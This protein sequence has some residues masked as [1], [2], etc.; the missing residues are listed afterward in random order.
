MQIKDDFQKLILV[1]EDEGL[2]AAD[3]QR[4]IERLGY[5][6]P[7]IARSGEE[8]L[9]R[10]R[11]TPFD[12]VLMDIRLKGEMDGVATAEALRSELQTSVVYL[13][14]HADQETIERAKLTEPLGYIL[15]PISDGDLRSVMQTSIYKA[16]MDRRLRTSEAWLA[17]TL[18]SVG[19]G[20][21]AT[22]SDG[23]VVFMNPCAERLTGWLGAEAQGRVLM[24][25]LG[26][27]E[28]SSRQPAK[29]PVFDLAEGENRTYT[30]VS[31]AG[32]RTLVELECFENRSADEVLGSIVTVRDIGIRRERDS[33]LLQ[34]ERME[35]I[36][37]LAGGLAHDFNNQLTVILGYADELG[38]RLTGDD[39]DQILEIQQAA[40]LAASTTT[41]LLALSRRGGVRFEVLNVND[42]ISEV[43]PMISHNL[44][45][46][47]ILTTQLGSPLGYIRADRAQFKQLFLHLALNAR[48]SMPAGGEMRIESSTLEIGEDSALARQYRPGTYVRLRVSDTGEGLDADT[49]SRIFEPRFNTMK[50]QFGSG[51]GLSMVHS[52]VLQG[53]GYIGAESEVGKGTSFEILLPCVGTFRGPNE[54]SG[55]ERSTKEDP[56][57]TI[58]L[59]EDEDGVRRMMHR[60][61][62]REGYQLLAARNAE[63]AEDIAGVYAEAIHV[64]VT[65]VVMPGMTGPQLAERL[66]P[67]RPQMQVLFV[68]GYRHDALDQ[69][70]LLGRGVHVLPKPF[71]PAQL[72]RQVQL[73]VTQGNRL[74]Q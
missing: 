52:I 33:R 23:E 14:A 19:E 18:R 49:L 70:G 12:L 26:L 54:V 39:R 45:K 48:A 65:D 10:A 5:P 3:I 7:A 67:L 74:V 56:T 9:R 29:N 20:I 32:V 22:N 46:T 36:A 69:Q 40:A 38:A 51:L 63:E 13:T 28:E 57:P 59:V 55:E 44:G 72:L 24:E 16:A 58:L 62:E 73:L 64:L 66:K 42:V 4:R 43:Q 61:L 30:L 27:F 15:K 53:G 35:A 21:V 1:V 41:Q 11:S 17:T 34:S 2:I 25:V 71:P 68:S 8:A 60:F 50:E 47:A 31:K 37:N 6:S